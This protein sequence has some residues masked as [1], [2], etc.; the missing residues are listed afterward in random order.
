MEK[1]NKKEVFIGTLHLPEDYVK[2]L[3]FFVDIGVTDLGISQREVYEKIL[4]FGIAIIAKEA[5]YDYLEE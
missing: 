5:V 4:K 2:A 1:S 3:E